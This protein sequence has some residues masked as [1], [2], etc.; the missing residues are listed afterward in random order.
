VAITAG[1]LASLAASKRGGPTGPFE[2][3]IVFL[4]LGAVLASLTWK[5]N[6]AT[7]SSSASAGDGDNKDSPKS[8]TIRDAMKEIINDPKIALVG[9]VQSLFEAAMYIFVLQWPPVIAKTIGA[10]FANT[11]KIP[12]GTIFSCF[13][14]CC[15][16]GSTVFSKCVD[17]KI[18]NEKSASVMLLMS[19]VAMAVAAS[20]AKGG[21]GTLLGMS[22]MVAL[23]ASFFVFE[24]G[25]GFYFPTIGTLRSKYLPD[26]SRSVIM[27]LFGI[28]LN[29]LV[30]GVFLSIQR[31]GV[32]GA[33]RV[34][35]GALGIATA[36][37][38]QLARMD[39][40][41]DKTAAGTSPEPALA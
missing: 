30:V 22:P 28:P 1:Q 12:Y 41:K 35:T 4:A 31:L 29:A 20:A 38:I 13:M 26:S 34:A 25:V 6:V 11:A 9:M 3:S 15:L 19:T 14:A 2:L 39:G 33:L 24:A 23:V 8:L 40:D 36:C 27:N 32:T 37:M 5:E 18:K 16:M 7:S 10:T 17:A 21:A